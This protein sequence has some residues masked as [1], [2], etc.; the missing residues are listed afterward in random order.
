M[1]TGLGQ[2]VRWD[3]I[4]TSATPLTAFGLGATGGDH[5]DTAEPGERNY[6]GGSASLFG[7]MK[8]LRGRVDFDVTDDTVVTLADRNPTGY[9]G[10]ALSKFT[11]GIADNGILHYYNNAKVGSLSLSAEVDGVLTATLNWMATKKTEGSPGSPTAATGSGWTWYQG[12]LLVAGQ[13]I[14]VQSFTS[15]KDNGLV[16]KTSLDGAG[17][18]GEKRDPVS[19]REGH[20][21][22]SLEVRTLEPL[23]AATR[24]NLTDDILTNLAFSAI[25]TR[26]TATYTHTLAGLALASASMPIEGGDGDLEFSYT[27]RAP[28]N[29]S[30]AWVTTYAAGA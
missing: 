29:L 28:A 5:E 14:E 30:T 17:S 20:E 10:S 15:T 25:F 3:A 16:A 7:V 2:Y 13:A 21:R 26:G 8:N 19:I 18:S 6:A 23:A 12:V 1:A 9:P 4:P 22:V 11:V 27:F 24:G